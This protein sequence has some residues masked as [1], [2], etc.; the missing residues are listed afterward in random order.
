[1]RERVSL[2]VQDESPQLCVTQSIT[3]EK[4]RGERKEGCKKSGS[5]CSL[6]GKIKGRRWIENMGG[7][8][9]RGH[10]EEEGDRVRVED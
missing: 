6:E 5:I 9:D 7:L 3:E 1:M 2:S 10:S 8:G 4:K